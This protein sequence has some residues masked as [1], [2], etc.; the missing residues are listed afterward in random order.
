MDHDVLGQVCETD[1]IA[2]EQMMHRQCYI[3]YARCLEEQSQ[4]VDKDDNNDGQRKMKGDFDQVKDFIQD[5]IMDLWYR[6]WS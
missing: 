3:D 6:I 1:L 2:K 5:A 4:D